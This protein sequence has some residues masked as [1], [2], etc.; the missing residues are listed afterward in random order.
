MYAANFLHF[1]L[2]ITSFHLTSNYVFDIVKSKE[3]SVIFYNKN[4]F[5]EVIL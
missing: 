3:K 2:N 1:L 4:R 5:N